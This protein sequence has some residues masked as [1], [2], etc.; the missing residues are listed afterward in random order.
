MYGLGLAVWLI[1]GSA[2]ASEPA[3]GVMLGDMSKQAKP[4]SNRLIHESS[5]YLQQHAH[6]PVDWYPWGEEAFARAARENKPI[7]LSI[8]YSTCHWCH[9]MAHESFEDP[10]VAALINRVFVAIKVDREERPDIDQVYMTVAQ[11]MTGSGGWPL[12]VMMTPDKRPFYVATYVPKHSRNGRVGLMELIPSVEKAWKDQRR[13][14]DDSADRITAMLG[15][16]NEV[17]ATGVGIGRQALDEAFEQLLQNYDGEYGGFGQTRKFP[18]PHNLRY[19]LRYWRQSGDARAL[20]MVQHTLNAMRR[21]GIYDQS[22]FGFHRYATERAWRLPHFEKMLYDQALISMVYI[23]AYLATGETSYADTVREVFTYVMR[24]MIS[25]EGVF[26]SAED[27]DSE[28]EEG[29]FYLWTPEEIRVLLGEETAALF[30]QVYGIEPGGNFEEE[31]TG[32]KTGRNILI[33]SASWIELAKRLDMPEDRLRRSMAEAGETLLKARSLRQRPHLDDKALT[34]WNGMMIAALAMG[35]AALGEPKYM[36][37]AERA[38]SFILKRMRGKDGRLLHRYRNGDAGIVATLD[39]YAFFVWGLLELYEAGFD[40]AMLRAALE[41]NRI[42]LADFEDENGGGLF[43]TA[44]DA[45]ALLVRP[46]DVGDGAAPSGNAVAL[47]NLLRL[48]RITGDAG[49]EAKAASIIQAFAGSVGASPGAYAHFMM[50]VDASLGDGVEVVIA[51]DPRADDTQ[52]MLAALRQRFLPH[53]VIVLKPAGEAGK[54]IARLAPFT[55]YQQPLEGKA[56]A[57]VCRN[58]TCKQPTTNIEE[59]LLLLSKES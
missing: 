48:A 45:E 12:N 25:P 34:D 26:Y 59:M 28:G 17:K 11:M 52:A 13:E 2:M 56:A 23:E 27:A 50:G 32:E 44:D 35:A 21:G 16:I 49:L 38:A 22:G 20:A 9:V 30:T 46:K 55:K 37:A 18:Q 43:L 39:D 53:A 15:Q 10:E 54:E 5:P 57:Y 41:L 3:G 1:A 24:D 36:A 19:L 40:P 7:L 33:Q 6:N 29:L 8:G 14:I 31:A 47:L 58:F 4:V 51:G 42:M